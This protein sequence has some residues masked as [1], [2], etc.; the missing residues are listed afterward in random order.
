MCHGNSQRHYAACG[1]DRHPTRTP[2]RKEHTTMHTLPYPGATVQQRPLQTPL[3]HAYVPGGLTGLACRIGASM[4]F[5]PVNEPTLYL[6]DPQ[7]LVL[8]DTVPGA[9]ATYLAE[10]V[11][12]PRLAALST[13]QKPKP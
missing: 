8:S 3:Y 10:I 13:P 4:L 7:R 11:L 9:M 5:A 1:Q 2:N 12:A 6:V